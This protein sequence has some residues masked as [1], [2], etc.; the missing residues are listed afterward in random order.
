MVMN[1]MIFK[2]SRWIT[3]AS[4]ALISSIAMAADYKPFILGSVSQASVSEVTNE[5]QASL[6]THGFEVVGRYQP[7]IETQVIVVTHKD[8]KQLAS[9]SNLGGFGAMLRV[10][11]VSRSG[12]TEVSYTN[13]TYLWN[14]YRMSGDI[15]PIQQRIEKTLGY[16]K[17]FGSETALSAEALREYH[18]KFLMP[19]F[20]DIDELAEYESYDAALKAVEAGLAAKKGGVSK[21]YRIDLP[22]KN[23]T[24]FGVA[25]SQGAPKDANILHQI[26]QTGLSHAAHLPYELLVTDNEVIALN[27]KFRIAINWPSLSMM[28]SGSFMSIAD[29]PDEIIDALQ[30]V[31]AP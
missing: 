13:P 14:V 16:S 20:D 18:Y 30:E 11:I 25:F 26:D 17:T 5:I 31:V 22:G 7:N 2:F 29:A 23:E 12:Q 27:A 24:V 8:L 19:Y 15:L 9:K 1:D 10:S 3:V 4:L 21:V 6:Q 28:G